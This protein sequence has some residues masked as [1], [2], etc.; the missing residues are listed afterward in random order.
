[1]RKSDA[2]KRSLT[3][4][5][6]LF[7][8][9][10]PNVDL[11]LDLREKVIEVPLTQLH[12]FN[13][14][15][16]KVLDDFAMQELVES[17]IQ[18]GVL[19]PGVVRPI[20]EGGYELIAGHRRRRACERA[21]LDQMPVIVRELDDDAATLAMVGSNNQREKVLPSEKAF[22]YKMM[23]DA[24]RRK[25]G[26]P[27][28]ENGGQLDPH[29]GK[30]RSSEIVAGDVG[31]SAKQIKRFIRLTE[32]IQP[33]LDMV[34]S[35]K[36]P[37]TVAV[38]LSYLAKEYQDVVLEV[39]SENGAKPSLEQAKQIRELDHA[40]RFAKQEVVDLIAIRKP[41]NAD[42]SI[43]LP[44]DLLTRCFPDHTQEQIESAVR[45]VL[46]SITMKSS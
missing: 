46:E 39:I 30:L 19:I 27:S 7:G 32:L 2:D 29:S 12:S 43:R 45:K 17:I 22:A 41:N 15:P 38:E 5:D 33:L 31:T 28:Q 26:R 42:T 18:N 37:F 36:L 8:T 10:T 16:F 25:A 3:S 24:I 13:N 4:L 23:V 35:N 14:H 40:D 20:G 1:M 11:T 44:S 9:E 21:G 34:D 6:D